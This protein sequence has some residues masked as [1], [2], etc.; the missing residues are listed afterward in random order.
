MQIGDD[1]EIAQ[2]WSF[3]VFQFHDFNLLHVTLNF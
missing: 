1:L 3:E 2:G